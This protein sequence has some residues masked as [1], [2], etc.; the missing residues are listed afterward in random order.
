MPLDDTG[1]GRR[2]EAL[3][4]IDQVIDLLASEDRWCKHQLVTDDGRRCIMGGLQAVH[5]TTVLVPPIRLAIRQVTGRNFRRIESFNDDDT[6]THTLVVTVLHQARNN[7]LNS[8]PDNARKLAA[9]TT[10]TR[11]KRQVHYVW[12]WLATS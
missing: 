7:I 2:M 8:T 6:T 11:W 12:G 5:G 10:I 1:F 3:E 4:K 9:E